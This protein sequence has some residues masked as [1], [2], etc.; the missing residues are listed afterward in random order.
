MED[1]VVY[2]VVAM[3]ERT[4]VFRLGI[5]VTKEFEH[6]FEV[7]YLPNWLFCIFVSCL[8]LCGRDGGEGLELS[9]EEAGWFAVAR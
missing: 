9:I 5:P 4:S 6:V 7:R 1:H 2:F 8:C 3:D